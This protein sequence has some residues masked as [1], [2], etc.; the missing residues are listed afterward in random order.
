MLPMATVMLMATPAPR[1]ARPLGRPL[2]RVPSVLLA[3]EVPVQLRETREL[4][5]LSA[6]VLQAP[7][8]A[9]RV[10]AV[11]A[12]AVLCKLPFCTVQATTA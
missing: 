2:Q 8:A 7:V 6:F 4:Q 9:T 3:A 12:P 1:S 10:L 11:M 5:L